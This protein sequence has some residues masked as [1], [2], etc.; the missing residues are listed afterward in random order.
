M[1]QKTA[2][3][4]LLKRIGNSGHGKVVPGWGT[5]PLMAAI[6]VLLLLFLVIMLQVYNQSLLFQGFSVDWNGVN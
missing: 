5:V 4:T 1:G 3:G 6:G 2:I